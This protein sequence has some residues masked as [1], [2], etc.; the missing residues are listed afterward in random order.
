MKTVLLAIVL[1]FTTVNTI[2]Q[3][4]IRTRTGDLLIGSVKEINEAELIYTRIDQPEGPIRRVSLDQISEV[5]YK[6]GT[7]ETFRLVTKVQPETVTKSNTPIW[8]PGSINTTG[9]T[10]IIHRKGPD[11][12]VNPGDRFPSESD[13][14]DRILGSGV[15]FDGMIGYGEVSRLGNN[16][17]NT[18]QIILNYNVAFGVRFGSKFYFGSHEKSRFG[19]NLAWIGVTATIS[20]SNYNYIFINPVSIGPS[21]S[22]KFKKQM[23]IEVNGAVGMVISNI[24]KNQ[25][26]IKYGLDVKWRYNSLAIGLDF[27]RA[28]NI[29]G[30]ASE[31][32]NIFSLTTGVKF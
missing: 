21:Y 3:D 23:G 13:V 1:I 15:Y 24:Y 2:A 7:K 27:S 18:N 10:V 29:Y 6:N 11:V 28:D 30:S 17:N 4:T 9:K 20:E 5:R 26:G 12:R 25:L 8:E 32:S 14:V 16:Y 22:Y 19:I 31:Y